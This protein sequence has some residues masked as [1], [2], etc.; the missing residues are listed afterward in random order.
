MGPCGGAQKAKGH[1]LTTPGSRNFIQWKV[2]NP[3]PSA[4]CTLRLGTGILDNA[5]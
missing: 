4:N 2:I 5:H 1:V 3:A